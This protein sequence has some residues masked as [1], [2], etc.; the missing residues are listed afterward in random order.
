MIFQK[1]LQLSELEKNLFSKIHETQQIPGDLIKLEF[2]EEQIEGIKKN[3]EIKD[4]EQIGLSSL[5]QQSTKI[6]K[7]LTSSKIPSQKVTSENHTEE[8]KKKEEPPIIEKKYKLISGAIIKLPENYSTDDEDEKKI[9]DAMNDTREEGW[10]EARKK[11]PV[12]VWKKKVRF[13]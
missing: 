2:T 12:T 9:V 7:T 1:Q 5:Q 6:K 13:K 8:S 10:E 3:G 4:K 11:D